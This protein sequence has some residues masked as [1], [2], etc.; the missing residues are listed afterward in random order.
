MLPIV[1]ALVPILG[2][3]LDRLIPDKAEA[4]RAK[5]EMETLLLQADQQ[6]KLAQIE[7]NKVEAGH[8]SLF[9]AGWRPAVGWICAAALAYQF[10]VYD[11]LSW[12][13]ALA[14]SITRFPAPNSGMLM[15]LVLAMLGMGGLR[16]F[17][18]MK[19]VAA[20]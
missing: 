15:E 9:V 4:A 8:S 19:G 12:A 7:L 16:T 2:E 10:I 6:A 11:L 13:A 1:G 18:K 17:E 14:G 3:V 20:K 5:V